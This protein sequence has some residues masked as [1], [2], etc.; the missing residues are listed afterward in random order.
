MNSNESSVYK[1]LREKILNLEFK[2]GQELNVNLLAEE[3][4]VSRSPI[5]DALLRLSVDNLVDIF[6]QKGTR[7]AFLNRQIIEQE[8]FLR[9][10]MELGVLR[11]FMKKLDDTCRQVCVTKLR[12]ILLEQHASLLAGNN[13]AFLQKDDELHHFFYTETSNEWLWEVITTHTGNDYRIRILSYDTDYIS[14]LVEKEHKELVDAIEKGDSEAAVKIDK[15]HMKNLSEILKG[16]VK[17]YP[18]YFSE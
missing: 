3:L 10:T 9:I 13:R 15:G 7:V 12:A 18:E 1:T 16:M 8:R 17:G 11:L 14:G 6:P 4:K 2:P 5:R